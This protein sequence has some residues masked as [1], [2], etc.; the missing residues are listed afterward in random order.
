MFFFR[1]LESR[2]LSAFSLAHFACSLSLSPHLPACASRKNVLIVDTRNDIG[3]D[4]VVPHRRAIGESRRIMVPPNTS[5]HRCLPLVRPQRYDHNSDQLILL[6]LPFAQHEVQRRSPSTTSRKKKAKWNKNKNLCTKS[7]PDHSFPTEISRRH[8][9]YDFVW[10]TG[11]DCYL[12]RGRGG[13][14]PMP[15][16]LSRYLVKPRLSCL[17]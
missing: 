4:A 16:L 6:R 3:G 15:I 10:R 2:Q 8:L 9:R 7:K 12:T 17:E 14:L 5:Q 1:V 13:S 11:I